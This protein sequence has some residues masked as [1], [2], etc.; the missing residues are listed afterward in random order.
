VARR[1]ETFNGLSCETLY[2]P[3][4]HL[5]RYRC[6][7]FG[8]F[9]LYAGRLDVLKR[10]SVLVEAMKKV[11]CGARLLVAGEG[12][13]GPELERQVEGLGLRDRVTLLGFVPVE[14]L[15]DLYARCRAAFY[16]PLNEDYGYVTVEAFLSGKPVVT[17]SDAGGVLEFVTDG[18]T[19]LVADPSPGALADAIDRLWA[20][21][22]PQVREMGVR[23]R[24]RV[25]GITWDNVIDALTSRAT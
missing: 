23:G 7:E 16:A 25:A 1:L 8:D 12:P 13:L 5:G 10:V 17:A 24:S 20:L 3:P 9:L 14:V 4:R 19:G 21:S 6:D 18:E 2:P 11:T 22:S 15:I